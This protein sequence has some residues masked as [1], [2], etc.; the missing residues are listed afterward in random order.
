MKTLEFND[1]QT[2]DV[3][4]AIASPDTKPRFTRKLL[5]LK[6]VANRLK[7]AGICSTLNI[8][9]ATLSS[10]IDEFLAGGLA[11]SLENKSYKPSSSIEEHLGQIAERFRDEPP[12]TAN[13]AAEMIEELCGVRLSECQARAIMLKK[14]KMGFRKAGTLPGKADGQ[15]QMD[16]FSNELEPRL[17]E[18]KEGRRQ[19]YFMDASHFLWGSY[20]DYSWCFERQWIPSASGRK[21]YNVLGA[22]NAF[23]RKLICNE[24]EGS[25]NAVTVCSLLIDLNNEHANSNESITI[26]LDNVPY[27]HAKIVKETAALLN[28]ELLF[29]PPYSP[30]LNL[31]ERAWKHLKKRVLANKH[32][33]TFE[34]FKNA[35]IDGIKAINTVERENMKSLLS[36][37]F[38]MFNL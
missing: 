5:A 2:K 8:T 37:N 22:I 1:Q 36:W 15:L 32:Y 38:Q 6:M 11:A 26:V 17:E 21:R 27:Q 18:A 16:F 19:V 12:S 34:L 29:L 31:I 33:K 30:N 23:T 20:P 24:T 28:I 10:Y 3:N 7:R 9:R 14:L 25:V 13:Q 35:I 4:E